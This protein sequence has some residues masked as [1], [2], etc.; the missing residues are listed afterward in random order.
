MMGKNNSGV[1][2]IWV[3]WTIILI[4]FLLYLYP[5]RHA[6]FCFDDHPAIEN[7]DVIKQVDLPRI[8]HAFNSRS[9]VGLSFALNYKWC[10]TDAAGYRLVNILIHCL[11]AFLVYLLIRSTLFLYSEGKTL[12][13]YPLE[14]PAL[15]ASMLFLCHPVQT[16]PVNFITQRFVLMGTFF[17]LLTLV[18]YIRYRCQKQRWYL[19]AAMATAVAAMFCKEFVVTLPVMMVLYDLYFLRTSPEPLWKHCRRLWPFLLIALIVPVLL[20]RTPKEAIGVANIAGF[21]FIQEG[22]AQRVSNQIDILRAHG[23]IAR[24]EYFLT[25]LNVVRTYVRLMVLPF[26]QNFDYDYPISRQVDQKTLLSAAFLIGLLIVAWGTYRS[27]RILSFGILWFF[28][29]LSVESSFIP[30]AHVI[31]EYRLYLASAG[32]CFIVMN[33][34]YMR[35]VDLRLINMI[36]AVVLIGFSVLTY[37]RNKVWKDEFTLWNDAVQKS[38]HKARPYNMRGVV[39]G[40]QGHFVQA[41]ADF[42]KAIEIDPNDTAAYCNRGFTYDD[43]GNL[44]AAISDYDH[45]IQIDPSLLYAYDNRGTA[46]GK[47]GKLSQAVSDYSR[48]IEINPQY[49]KAYFNRGLAYDLQKDFLKAVSDYSKA[50]AINAQYAQAYNNRGNVQDELGRTLQA[51]ADYTRAVEI[52]PRYAEAY[53]NRGIDY[54]NQGTLHQA[55]LDFSKAIEINPD[56]AEAYN[57]RGV[58]YSK[59]KEYDKAWAD[60][61]KAESLGYRVDTQFLLDLR[62]AS[63]RND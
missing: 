5:L 20:S 26:N 60:V 30:I 44:P 7:N 11:N 45:A 33:L 32:F 23:G 29:A 57:N 24:K 62:K 16:E 41:I 46:Y 43:Q 10:G 4:G 22:D 25:E 48:A 55:I 14:W 8:F 28:T 3:F 13:Y 37:Q 51:L 1:F 2:S 40:K 56:Y 49:A 17:Y 42:S 21:N 58:V 15:F 63:G 34:I 47:Q 6:F 36:A 9:L 52:N 27:Y 18:L 50:V 39:Y 19:A 12:F 38:P 59:G 54:V 61:H 31:A 35:K 53:D